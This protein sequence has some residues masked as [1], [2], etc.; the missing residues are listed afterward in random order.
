VRERER[1]DEYDVLETCRKLQIKINTKNRTVRHCGHLSRRVAVL[2][3]KKGRYHTEHMYP[4]GPSYKYHTFFIHRRM[5][6]YLH[7]RYS[8]TVH[9]LSLSEIR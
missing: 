5:T 4:C 8:E 6:H 1:D 9:S 2:F 3:R 7:K